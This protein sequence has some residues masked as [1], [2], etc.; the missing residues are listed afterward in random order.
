I[1]HLRNLT[2]LMNL[3]LNW[4]TSV[5]DD[6]IEGLAPLKSLTTFML[7]KCS[8]ITT[9]GLKKISEQ[10]RELRQLDLTECSQID[11]EG[12]IYLAKN[13]RDLDQVAFT[14]CKFITDR[15]ICELT[16]YCKKLEG[17]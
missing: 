14:K 5:D 6:I 17:I 11:D 3:N 16:K 2:T 7:A 4:V 9:N 8:K 13:C 12:V 10:F 15:S 1:K